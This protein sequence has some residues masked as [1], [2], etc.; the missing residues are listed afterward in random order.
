M[1]GGYGTAWNVAKFVAL[2]AE[3]TAKIHRAEALPKLNQ[4]T[5][6]NENE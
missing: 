3:M 6:E 1:N 5:K 4:E 2:S